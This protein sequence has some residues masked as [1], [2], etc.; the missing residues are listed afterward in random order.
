M[1]SSGRTFR[2]TALATRRRFPS[3]F[4]PSQSIIGDPILHNY[5]IFATHSICTMATSL[6]LQSKKKLN[7]G[8]DIP[9]LGYGVGPTPP[10]AII[11]TSLLTSAAYLALEDVSTSR[12]PVLLTMNFTKANS[13]C[14]PPEQAEEVTTEA[15]KVGYRHVRPTFIL[16]VPHPFLTTI[17]STQQPRTRMKPVP[18]APSARLRMSPAPISSSP[19]RFAISTTMAPRTRSIRLSRRRA[20]STST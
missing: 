1:A 12:Y 13:H 7:S 4:T 15:I 8:Y 9:V 18:V 20:S 16:H 2:T 11:V 14:S 10:C 5:S 6:T 3:L 17:R 19:P